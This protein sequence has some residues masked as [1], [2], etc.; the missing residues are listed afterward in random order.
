MGL[1][2][3]VNSGLASGGVYTVLSGLLLGCLVILGP[4]MISGRGKKL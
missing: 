2:T 3:G 1:Y 4:R